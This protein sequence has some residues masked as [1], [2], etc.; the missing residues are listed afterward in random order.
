MVVVS[1]IAILSA[2]A[3]P[4]YLN[5]RKRAYTTE[6]RAGLHGIRTL[7]RNYFFNNDIYADDIAKLDFK[8]EGGTRYH[9]EILGAGLWGF[10]AQATANLDGDSVIDTWTIET[11]GVYSHVIV[12]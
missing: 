1:I 12:D 10:S 7:Q 2:I 11:T 6:A 8:M 9:Y 5:F 4:L 3:V